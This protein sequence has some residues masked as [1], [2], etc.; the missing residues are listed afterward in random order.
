MK[1]HASPPPHIRPALAS[2]LHEMQAIRTAAF[3]P[4]FASFRHMLGDEVYE[5]AQRHEDEAQSELLPSL[6]DDGHWSVF[7]ALVDDVIVGFVSM[8]IDP[9]RPVGEIGLNAVAP[10][11]AGR[12]IGTHMY[13]Y[14][15]D[16]MRAA[17]AKVA[18][19]ATGGDPSHAPARRAYARVG[20]DRVTPGL[21]MCQRLE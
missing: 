18:T 5:L 12:G 7:V 4:I 15:L 19:V 2:D 16:Q 6:L 8:R 10:R 17:G 9:E 3:A 1:K 11:M 20:F 21:W 14:A 13:R